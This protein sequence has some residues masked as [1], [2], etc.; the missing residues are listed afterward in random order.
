MKRNITHILLSILGDMGATDVVPEVEIADT[1]EHGE[2]TTNVAMRLTKLLKKAPM[3]IGQEIVD[4]LEKNGEVKKAGIEKIE[5]VQPGFIN[6]FLAHQQSWEV[7][8]NIIDQGALYGQ[9]KKNN[10]IMIIDYS[11]PN[12]AKR[13]GIGHLRSTIVG[14]T[15]ERLYEFLGWTVI[16]DNHLGDWGTQFGKMIV[17]IRKW[18]NGNIKAMTIEELETLYIKFHT[19]AE[20]HPELEDEARLAFRKLEEGNAEERTM[21]KELITI[22]MKEFNK[23]YEILNVQID[24]TIGESFYEKIMLDVIKDAKDKK[25]TLQSK[26]AWIIQYPHD[27]LPPSMLLKSDGGTTYL[28]RDLATIK[29]RKEKWNPDRMI[30]EVGGEQALHFRQVFWAAEM[31][32]YAKRDSLVHVG[33]G[34]IRL[35]EGKMSTRKGRTI[36][37]EE[38]LT[39]AV[40]KAEKFTTD[41]KIAEA[42]GIGAVKYNDLKRSPTIGY[43]FDWDEALNLEGN[44]GPYIQYVFVRCKSVLEK[45]K[46]DTT[47]MNPDITDYVFNTDE[48]AVIREL[49]R[50]KEVINEA[51]VRYS[52]NVLCNYLFLLSQQ[53]NTFYNSY[54]ILQAESETTISVRIFI[55]RAVMQIIATGLKILGIQTP[56]K[57]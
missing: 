17:A 14:N 29:F 7:I 38:V 25:I 2:Y 11:A 46:R 3:A 41:K 1:P 16:G 4:Q 9:V 36:K 53:F 20:T 45:S 6:F 22:S 12:I 35:P 13:F 24:E 32:G 31:L 51:A 19:E 23:I 48:L 50:F 15:L 57:M 26:G 8:Q 28:T 40:T 39:K 44:S 55:T 47:Q 37:L 5:V 52:P 54:S 33:H 18:T 30:Y 21:W 43:S 10:K 56:H 49:A 42:I 27:A 34:M